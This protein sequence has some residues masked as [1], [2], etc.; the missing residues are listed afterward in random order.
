[1]VKNIKRYKRDKERDPSAQLYNAAG[2]VPTLVP[3]QRLPPGWFLLL[4]LVPHVAGSEWN[5]T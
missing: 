5:S 2:E 1:M 4:L 3:L